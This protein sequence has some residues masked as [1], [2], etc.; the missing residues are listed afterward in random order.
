MYSGYLRFR[1]MN[2]EENPRIINL[3]TRYRYDE[4]YVTV[5]LQLAWDFVTLDSD[6][7]DQ[8]A[9]KA[10]MSNQGNRYLLIAIDYFT[11]WPEAHVIPNQEA[12]TV[13]EAVVTD[14]FF[15]FGIPLELHSDQGRKF[16][17]R[18]LQEV[19]QRLGV[20]NV[21]TRSRTAW[22][23]TQER[24]LPSTRGIGKRDYPSLS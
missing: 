15:C 18:L 21:C 11:T 23:S 14:V 24:L 4:S 10:P 19:P 1:E 22:R 3:D 7:R 17:S 20:S 12:S 2:T 8:A 13:A 6:I 16:Q 9:T 5:R